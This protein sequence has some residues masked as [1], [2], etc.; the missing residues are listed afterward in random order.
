MKQRGRGDGDDPSLRA[1]HGRLDFEL[2]QRI[3]DSMKPNMQWMEAMKQR[4]MAN[5]QRYTNDQRNSINDWH[6]RQMAIINAGGAAD[7]HAIRMRTNHEVAGISAPWPPTPAPPTTRSTRTIDGIN[8][9]NRYAGTDG[10]QV[11]SSIHGGS[12][13]FR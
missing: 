5:L 8:E 1:P 6:N 13:V 2:T 4:S 12:R 11:V 3:A 10:S 9:V 7:R